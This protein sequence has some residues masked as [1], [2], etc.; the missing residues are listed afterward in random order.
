[1]PLDLAGP[2]AGAAGTLAIAFAL[3]KAAAPVRLPLGVALTPTVAALFGSSADDTELS[4]DKDSDQ[5]VNQEAA[6]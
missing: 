3:H 2:G 6:P 5:S 1:M 4:G